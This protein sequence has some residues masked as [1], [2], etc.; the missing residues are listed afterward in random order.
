MVRCLSLLFFVYFSAR[1]YSMHSPKRIAIVHEWFTS[2]RG[3]EKCVE[4]LCELFPD[5]TLFTLLHIGGMV[6]PTIEKMEIKT[7]FVQHLPFASRHY[8]YYLPLFPTAVQQFDLR[9]YDLVISSSHCVAKGVRAPRGALHVCYC[10]TPMRYLWVQRE[11][12]FG[13]G[14]AGLVT[15][16]GVSAVERYLR[17][18]DVRTAANPDFFVAISENVRTRIKTIYRRDADM[19]YPPVNTAAFR[20]SLRND[21]YFLIVSALVPYKRVDLAIEAFNRVGDRLVIVG[22]GPESERLRRLA[23][24][25]IEFAGWQSDEKI[26]EYYAGCTAVVFPGEE[27]FGIVPVEAMASGKPVLAYARG[28]AL[29][30]VLDTPA[31]RT[32]VL[33]DQPTPEALI[34]AL[35]RL[36][37]SSFDSSALRSF[38]LNFDREVFKRGFKEYIDRRWIEFQARSPQALT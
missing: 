15:R 26:R 1:I 33:F 7:S 25:N 12:Y 24:R 3:G 38:A 13:R 30:T 35:A 36:K 37:E 9:G 11:Q 16:L 20:L 23:G 21:G 5:A 4:A 2:M 14:R 29:E 6:S 8:R 17:R 19:I 32:G 18:W 34:D 10:Y 31:L 27:D 28:G 22:D